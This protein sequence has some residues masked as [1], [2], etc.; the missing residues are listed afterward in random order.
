MGEPFSIAKA[1]VGEF[2]LSF[3]KFGFADLES[4]NVLHGRKLHAMS[5]YHLQQ[6]VEKATK[7]FGL[8]VGAFRP[9]IN[10]LAGR[11][12]RHRPL[13]MLLRRSSSF[14]LPLMRETNDIVWL[15]PGV[16]KFVKNSNQRLL[17]AYDPQFTLFKN[18][19]VLESQQS[20]TKMDS[21]SMR[22]AT[23]SLDPSVPQVET[24]MGQLRKNILDRR[25]VK[26]ALHNARFAVY[27]GRK[28]HVDYVYNIFFAAS[29]IYRLNML[30]M[31]HESA[32]RY[33]TKDVTKDVT[34]DSFI[35]DS[36]KPLIR[37]IP[38]L[39]SQTR[40]LCDN[41]ASAASISI[42]TQKVS[43]FVESL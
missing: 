20:L 8:L 9:D 1:E 19:L 14:M 21:E 38:L 30:T 2:A 3:V 16:P 10:E 41:V 17:L 28:H 27:Q 12:I 11:R 15:Q 31:W 24:A 25:W 40:K 35:Y 34:N 4:A 7:G 13:G 39:L 23:L 22:R 36:K 18:Q 33:P 37:E 32:T 43:A 42:R 6:S 26:L 5:L 29:R